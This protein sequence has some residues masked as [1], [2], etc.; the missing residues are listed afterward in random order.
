MTIKIPPENI[1]DKI[2][3]LLGK[4]RKIIMPDNKSIIAEKFGPYVSISAKRENVLKHSFLE[5][6]LIAYEKIHFS[7]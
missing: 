7:I 3:A 2:S 1:L 6:R 4:I 5:F